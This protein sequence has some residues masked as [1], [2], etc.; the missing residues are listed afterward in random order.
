MHKGG[1]KQVSGLI[2]TKRY[3]KADVK[4]RIAVQCATVRRQSP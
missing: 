2:A 1:D 3:A 4:W